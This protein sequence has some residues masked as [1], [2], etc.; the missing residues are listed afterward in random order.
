[1]IFVLVYHAQHMRALSALSKMRCFDESAMAW[2]PYIC[3]R[4][5]SVSSRA[6][7]GADIFILVVVAVD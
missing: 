5:A 4:E 7:R 3:L 2:I 1:M 6:I